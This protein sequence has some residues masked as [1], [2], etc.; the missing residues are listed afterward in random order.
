MN[1]RHSHANLCLNVL[2]FHIGALPVVKEANIQDC[3]TGFQS[4][5]EAENNHLSR[6]ILRTCFE[7]FYA[8]LYENYLVE[9]PTVKLRFYR[10]P[11]IS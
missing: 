8:I 3:F 6:A 7:N 10:I 9:K 4:E 1:C 5:N 2:N 11:F